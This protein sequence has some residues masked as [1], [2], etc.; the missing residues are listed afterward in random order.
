LNNVIEAD[1]GKLKRWIKLT[2][3]FQSLKTA[4]ATLKG[5]EV[6][7]AQKKR[8]GSGFSDPGR[9]VRLVERAFGLG[10]NALAETLEQY[11]TQHRCRSIVKT[12]LFPS[13]YETLIFP[14]FF[15]PTSLQHL[16]RCHCR[17]GCL[18]GQVSKLFATKLAG[19]KYAAYRERVLDRG[20]AAREE[21]GH[22]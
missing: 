6:M 22:G 14:R 3:G 8:Q 16:A 13:F 10:L 21:H 17:Y 15:Q 20:C 12:G 9:Q 18:K 11:S 2:L 4:H 5:F 19:A 1:H 7:L